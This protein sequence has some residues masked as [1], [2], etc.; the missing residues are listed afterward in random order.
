MIN[1]FKV[2][3][4]SIDGYGWGSKTS[5]PNQ[6][7]VYINVNHNNS[8]LLDVSEEPLLKYFFEWLEIYGFTLD[9]SN[10]HNYN[11]NIDRKWGVKI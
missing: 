9:V 4:E 1:K 8:R 10:P 5:D 3:N 7:V 11:R 6:K 2:F